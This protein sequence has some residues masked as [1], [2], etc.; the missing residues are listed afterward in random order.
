L[1]ERDRETREALHL[2]GD[3]KL[4]LFFFKIPRQ[5][6]LVLL[7]EICLR[8]HEALGSEKVILMPIFM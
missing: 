2:R 1:K 5:C 4:F 6:P 7:V 8:E 3:K